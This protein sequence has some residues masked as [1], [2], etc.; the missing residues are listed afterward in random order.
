ME[1]RQMKKLMEA[2]LEEIEREQ[3]DDHV[4]AFEGDIQEGNVDD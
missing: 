3:Q 4:A 2:A 1:E